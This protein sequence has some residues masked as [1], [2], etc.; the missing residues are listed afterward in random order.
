MVKYTLRRLLQAIPTLF[1]ITILS[2]AL[3][4]F[5]PGGPT[6]ALAV[7]PNVNARERAALA[8]RLGVS[9]PWPIQ[10]LRW[11][12][13]DD[14]MRVDTDGDGVADLSRIIPL[15]ADGD[16]RPEPPGNR[17]GILRL[18]FGTSF[19]TRRPVMSMISEK[20]PA[21][22]ELGFAALVVSLILGLP[23][24][25]LAAVKHGGWFDNVTRVIAV[26][27]SAIPI[28]WLGLILIL[29]FGSWLKL[30]PMGSQ[31]QVVLTG[32]CPPIYD[33]LNYLLLPTLVLSTGGIAI[34]S[35]FMRASMLEVVSQDYIRTARAKGLPDSRVWFG[36]AARNALIPIATF[37]GPSITG[38]LGGAVITETIFSW[39][40]LGR[41]GVTS[42][43][44]QDYPVVMA[45]VI[46]TSIATVVG[47]II[48]DILYAVIDPRIRFN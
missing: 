7:N 47:F 23:I 31:C 36:H 27:F 20:I 25:I 4:Y 33:R 28:F 21:T 10:Y 48:S 44:Q 9:D 1:G 6:S 29:V 45:V 11:L 24:G 35:R 38:L 32:G 43:V 17:Y 42:V 39:P 18:D 15:D 14:W 19:F 13:G 3:M 22:L 12:V 8:A 30:L 37:L 26:M 2:F 5:A 46:I 16:E 34:N 41:L 40:G